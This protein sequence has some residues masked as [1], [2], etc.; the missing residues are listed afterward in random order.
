[1]K[2]SPFCIFAFE[3]V[4]I[5]IPRLPYFLL[6]ASADFEKVKGEFATAAKAHKGSVLFIFI[7]IADEENE[8]ILEFFGLTKADCPTIRLINLGDDMTKFKPETVDLT[9]DSISS[10]VQDF[11]DG[12]LKPFLMSEEVRLRPL[13]VL[14]FFVFHA[15]EKN[16][17][18]PQIIFLIADAKFLSCVHDVLDL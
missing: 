13:Q 2:S 6:Q 12:K 11:K 1:M 7:N 18:F 8:R 17:F 9:A 3:N 15:R 4:F 16:L 10:F 14:T 5:R